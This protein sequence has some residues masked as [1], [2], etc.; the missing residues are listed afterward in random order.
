MLDPIRTAPGGRRADNE[1]FFPQPSVP[2][3]MRHRLADD[4]PYGEE[5]LNRRL[6]TLTAACAVIVALVGLT[7]GTAFA[8]SGFGYDGLWADQTI[9]GNDGRT[10]MS[11]PVTTQTQLGTVYGKIELRYS[12]VCRT[13]W[14]RV[15][16]P[17]LPIQQWAAVSRNSEE[18]PGYQE[19]DGRLWSDSLNSFYCFTAML[20]DGGMT[21]FAAGW[22]SRSILED[23]AYGYTGSY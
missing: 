7:P 16:T 23:G 22:I 10:V 21:S 20:Y 18:H 5:P 17:V 19:C 3:C 8:A 2:L 1:R 9:C 14:A 12:K 13:V 4:R 11:A 15:T 6:K